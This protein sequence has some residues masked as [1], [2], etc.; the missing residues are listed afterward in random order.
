MIITNQKPTTATSHIMSASLS[1]KD[2]RIKVQSLLFAFLKI[3]R[4]LAK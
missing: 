4:A 1:I 2:M 3:I